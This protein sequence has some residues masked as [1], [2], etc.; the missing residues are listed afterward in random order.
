MVFYF[1]SA[2]IRRNNKA[3]RDQSCVGPVPDSTYSYSHVAIRVSLLLL[4]HR[5]VFRDSLFLAYLLPLLLPHRV[6]VRDDR[7]EDHLPHDAIGDQ[8]RVSLRW[9]PECG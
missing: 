5:V 9:L 3:D 1:C 6:A 8:G 4:P 7:P 2:Q